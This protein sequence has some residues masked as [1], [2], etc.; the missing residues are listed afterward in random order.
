MERNQ[1]W[2]KSLPLL[3]SLSCYKIPAWHTLRSCMKIRNITE[4]EI[5]FYLRHMF[6]HS[7]HNNLWMYSNAICRNFRPFCLIKSNK[8]LVDVVRRVLCSWYT[9]LISVNLH[10]YLLTSP[11][12]PQ[13]IPEQFN[14]HFRRLNC[15]TA[16]FLG[17]LC[18]CTFVHITNRINQLTKV[19]ELKQF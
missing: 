12:S 4:G 11:L 15:S 9:R 8:K 18:K 2:W 6:V 19:P 16:N 5:P 17:L 3:S 14:L 7:N 1:V 10:V 13:P